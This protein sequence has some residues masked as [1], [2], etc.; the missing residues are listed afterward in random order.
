MEMTQVKSREE[1]EK[2]KENWKGDPCWDIEETEGFEDYK[3]QL[4]EYRLK[5]QSE[6][7]AAEYN[8]IYNKAQGLG[9]ENLGNKDD[10]PNLQLVK[11]LETLERRIDELSQ[12]VENI[13]FRK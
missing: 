5:Q 7:R 1:V 13:Y 12:A 2:L 8:R 10:E 3:D 9:I 4:K 6:W 11:Y